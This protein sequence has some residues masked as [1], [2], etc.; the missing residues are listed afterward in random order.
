MMLSEITELFQ[1]RNLD[2]E[3]Q[4]YK[5]DIETFNVLHKPT[6]KSRKLTWRHL[7]DL[8]A[9]DPAVPLFR[10]FRRLWDSDEGGR[11]LLACQMGL[12]R[13]PLLRLSKET[14]LQLEPGQLLPRENME[15]AFA[16]RCPDRFSPATLK[17]VAQNVNGTWKNAGFLRGR[18]K[19]YRTEPEVHP[20]NVVFA[21]FLGYLQ[22]ATGIRLFTTEWAQ[23]LGCRQEKLLELARQASYSG[24]VTF[25]HSSEVV[26]VTFPDYL[27]K[28]EETWLYG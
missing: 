17:S 15:Q 5:E 21:L 2:A 22:G 1:G 12:A 6:E 18:T 7:V 8:Y 11:N 26:E 23:L 13:D 14:I 9:M 4:Q 10:A 16:E 3:A 27:T 19:K 28:E 25:K 20:V 24:L